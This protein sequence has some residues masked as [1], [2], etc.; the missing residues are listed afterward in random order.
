MKGSFGYLEA[1]GFKIDPYDPCVEN[2]MVGGKQI[3][4]F[5]HVDDQKFYTWTGTMCQ[6]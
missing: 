1:Y 2:K 3:T 5:W 4:V 6:R